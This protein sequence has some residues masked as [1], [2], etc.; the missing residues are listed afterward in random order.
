MA[1]HSV[2]HFGDKHGKWAHEH[3]CLQSLLLIFQ[4]SL[5]GEKLSQANP[6]N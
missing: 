3:N 5:T 6:L 4:V 1:L 2:S